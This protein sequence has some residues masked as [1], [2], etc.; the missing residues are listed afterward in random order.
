MTKI[1]DETRKSYR[2]SLAE[3]CAQV[4]EIRSYSDACIT[5][6]VHT[7]KFA[8]WNSASIYGPHMTGEI[9]H[10]NIG[11]ELPWGINEAADIDALFA[12][13][14]PDYF[15]RETLAALAD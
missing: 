10:E 9:V 8:F 11:C 1:T 7:G 14:D 2:A 13:E 4:K 5:F 12:G 6:E 15:I 3:A